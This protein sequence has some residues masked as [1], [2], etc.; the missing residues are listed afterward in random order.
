MARFTKNILLLL[1]VMLFGQGGANETV[2]EKLIWKIFTIDTRA[3]LIS[4]DYEIWLL[5]RLQPNKSTWNEWVRRKDVP[6]PDA[7]YLISLEKWEEGQLV[8]IVNSPWKDCKWQDNYRGDT[9]ILQHCNF[10]IKN[11]DCNERVFAKSLEIEEWESIYK[12]LYCEAVE[13]SQLGCY[14]H[15]AKLLKPEIQFIRFEERIFKELKNKADGKPFNEQYTSFYEK[16]NLR[17]LIPYRYQ[18]LNDPISQ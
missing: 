16:Y 6:Q 5:Q 17:Q 2:Q 15:A 18:N 4:N 11:E 14:G 8:S 10:V 9:S 12:E 1:T 7:S 13:K 3:V